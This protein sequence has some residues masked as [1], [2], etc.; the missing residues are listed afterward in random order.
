[1]AGAGKASSGP[2]PP[3]SD[4]KGGGPGAS[5]ASG[6]HNFLT[7]PK[8]SGPATGSRDFTK[9]SRSQ[10]EAS[11]EVKPNPQEIPTGG[12]VLLADPGPVSA[13]VSGTA[14]HVEHKPFKGM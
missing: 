7:D 14:Q 4:G 9:E 13:K 11:E 12:K 10:S 1:M 3:F 2:N 5:T 6:A 8:G